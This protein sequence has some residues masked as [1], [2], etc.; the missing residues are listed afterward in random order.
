V[1]GTKGFFSRI[2]YTTLATALP[3]IGPCK[4]RLSLVHMAERVFSPHN[5]RAG[6]PDGFAVCLISRAWLPA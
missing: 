1:A 4:F 5:A 6:V 3:C 2:T